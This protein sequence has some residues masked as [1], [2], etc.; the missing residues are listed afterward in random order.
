[1]LPVLRPLQRWLRRGREPVPFPV[2]WSK[3]LDERVPLA[4]ALS[5]TDRHELEQLV[6]VFLDEK[7][8]EGAGGLTITDEVRVTIAAQA[9]VLLLHRD[10]DVY[11]GLDTVLVYPSTYVV[12]GSRREGAVVIDEDSARLGESWTKGLVVLAWDAVQRATTH[13]GAGHNVVVHEFAH[14]LDAEDGSVDGAPDLGTSTRYATWARVLGHEY[15][16]LVARIHAGRPIDIDSYGATNPPEFFAV[17]TEMF[18]ERPTRLKTRHPELY[19]VLADFYRQ[20][21]GDV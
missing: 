19:E 4:R 14:Q 21:P 20:R 10:S 16:D 5:A 17:I 9:C 13:P 18:F 6:V 3:I 7:T 2:A 1:M 8:F 12:P 15:E 11:P